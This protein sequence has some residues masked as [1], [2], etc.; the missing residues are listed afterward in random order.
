[1]LTFSLKHILIRLN[2]L[3]I[4]FFYEY[5]QLQNVPLG[6]EEDQDSFQSIIIS[7]G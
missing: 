7:H 4:R 2:K 1:M 3:Q 6:K 5:K